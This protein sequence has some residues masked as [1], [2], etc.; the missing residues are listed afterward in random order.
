[1][2]FKVLFKIIIA[3]VQKQHTSNLTGV[4]FI[5]TTT[6]TCQNAVVF[7]ILNPDSIMRTTHTRN[8]VIF[9]QADSYMCLVHLLYL[10]IEMASLVGVY[11]TKCLFED[12]A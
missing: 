8:C 12:I 5:Y 7:C 10:V 2:D 3:S 11:F 4:P 9:S 1:M 6:I